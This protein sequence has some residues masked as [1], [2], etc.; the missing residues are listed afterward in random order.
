MLNVVML[1]VVRRLLAHAFGLSCRA[2]AV[3]MA[4]LIVTP[5]SP[6]G[7]NA[8]SLPSFPGAE[9]FGAYAA[10][11]RGGRVIY[12]TTLATSGPGSLQWALD[13]P[14]KRYVLFKVSGLINGLVHLRR[15]DVTIAGE[16][17]PA[18]ITVRGFVT[19]EQPFQDQVVKA[20][21]RFAQNWILR[22]I[23]MRPGTNGPDGD[24]LRLRY[25]RN[26]IV[27]GVSIGNAVDEAVEISYSNNITVQRS[28]LAETLGGHA[29]YGGLLMNYSNPRHGFALDRVSLHHNAFI[30][31]MGRL[32]EA[33]R[34]SRDAAY[35]RQQLEVANNLYWDPAF[36]IMLGADTNIITG[37][38]GNP[39]PIYTD[40]NMVGNRMVVRR[41]FPYGMFDDA[42]AR[43]TPAAPLNRLFVRDNSIDRY[44]TRAD[45]QLFY[46]CNDFGPG[47]PDTSPITANKR[48]TRHPFPFV[49][50]HRAVDLRAWMVA[51]AGAFPR[52][53]MDRRLTGYLAANAIATTA[54]NSNPAGD[55]LKVAFTGLAPRPPVDTDSDGMPDDWERAKGLN[56]R[57][58]GANDRTLSSRGY[59]NL[60]VYL[61]ERAS[62]IRRPPA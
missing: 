34:E 31:I 52:D 11:G 19:D 56:P 29:F 36:M 33:S 46:C 18:G 16:T 15:G 7:A 21:G 17:S 3:A 60:E 37:A 8:S 42:I 12:V 9:G 53:P 1:N 45:Y 13:Q 50:Y 38:N 2:R 62:A 25:T 58:A 43:R 28:I 54:Q 59:T 24:G 22:N 48:L 40:L 23:R 61:H 26:A 30:R 35:T 41:T 6:L 47:G 14:G 10:G 57:V 44:P 55:T 32:P 5:L 49:T 39:Y 27:D 20:P 51:N 4:A